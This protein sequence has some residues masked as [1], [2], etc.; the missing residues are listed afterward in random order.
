M[1]QGILSLFATLMGL[2]VQLA[3]TVTDY[4]DGLSQLPGGGPGSK[5][6]RLAVYLLWHFQ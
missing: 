5:S 2:W 1:P 4:S 6:R 3:K